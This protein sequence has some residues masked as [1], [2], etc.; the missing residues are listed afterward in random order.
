MKF[1]DENV[2]DA[3]NY[4]CYYDPCGLDDVLFTIL[5]PDS[6]LLGYLHGR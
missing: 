1:G 5:V 4:S 3:E 2:F 6:K